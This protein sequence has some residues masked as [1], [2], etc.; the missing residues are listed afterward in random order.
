MTTLGI[1]VPAHDEV[2]LLPRCL[3]H[4]ER[5]RHRLATV[6]PTVRVRTVVAVDRC[7][8]ETAAV[9]ACR[10]GVEI[11]HLDARAVGAARAAGAERLLHGPAPVDW[12]ATTDADTV[13]PRH[14]LIWH[15]AALRA[16]YDLLLGT[17]WPEGTGLTDAERQEWL[18]RHDLADGHP[19]VHGA[20][21]GLS[22]SAYRLVGGFQPLRVH[23][24]LDL[25]T[26]V[27]DAGLPWTA[28]GAGRVV[29]SD[30]VTGRVRGGFADYL[31]DLREG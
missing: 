14:W 15:L 7:S 19:H 27:R 6:E 3:D 9:A 16:G 13:V 2:A 5:A 17:V 25:V 8:D 29:T 30:R 28:S 22:A 4:L 21:L 1:V 31:A 10:D 23:E 12:V 20:N 18:G 24:D 26:R 11:V